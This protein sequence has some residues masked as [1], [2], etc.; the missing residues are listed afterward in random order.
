MGKG[1]W[2]FML[3]MDLLLPI[4]MFFFGNYFQNGEPKKI[5]WAFGYR[6]RRSMMNQDTWKFAHEY[7]GKLWMRLGLILGLLTI[8]SLL[9]VRGQE[10]TIIGKAGAIVCYVQLAFLIGSIFFVERALKKKFDKDGN[11]KGEAK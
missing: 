7:C 10:E 4:I 2:F 5:N 8:I 6:T 1:F 3:C 9:F 11:R